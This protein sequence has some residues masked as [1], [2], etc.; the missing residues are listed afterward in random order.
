M[1][2]WGTRTKPDNEQIVADQLLT[3]ILTNL[4]HE[5]SIVLRKKIWY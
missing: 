3:E 4:F 2:Y 1:V 5:E